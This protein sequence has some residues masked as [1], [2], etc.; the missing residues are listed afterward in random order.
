MNPDEWQSKGKWQEEQRLER[1]ERDK[2]E[3]VKRENEREADKRA[4]EK[5][6]IRDVEKAIL[7]TFAVT[8][9][10]GLVLP[11]LLYVIFFILSWIVVARPIA[12]VKT[13]WVRCVL[14]VLAP[15]VLVAVVLWLKDQIRVI[16]TMGFGHDDPFE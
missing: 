15:I 4:A 12:R 14:Y 10:I 9:F 2:E 13:I 6:R 16:K 3:A 5:H 11:A 1:E 8:G 7:I